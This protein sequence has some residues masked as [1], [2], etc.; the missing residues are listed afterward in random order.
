[1]LAMYP[2]HYEYNLKDFTTFL[3]AIMCLESLYKYQI[4]T[5]RLAKVLKTFQLNKASFV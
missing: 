5:Q 2:N 3:V 1:M 4:E